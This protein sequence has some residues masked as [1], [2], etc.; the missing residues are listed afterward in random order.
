MPDFDIDAIGL[1]HTG[2]LLSIVV[3]QHV[4]PIIDRVREI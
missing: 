2:E 3:M 4:L 1:F